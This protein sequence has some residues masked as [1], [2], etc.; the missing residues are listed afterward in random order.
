M[1]VQQQPRLGHTFPVLAEELA[2]LRVLRICF[3]S[4]P[5]MGRGLIK[6]MTSIGRLA[7]TDGQNSQTYEGS[8]QFMLISIH[9]RKVG[10]E[11]LLNTKGFAESRFRFRLAAGAIH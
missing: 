10:S 9:A 5:V 8:G 11:L 6:A 7:L 2:V 3:E 1:L 4:R